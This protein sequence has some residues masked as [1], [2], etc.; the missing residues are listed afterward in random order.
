[1][2]LSPRRT[3]WTY[4]LEGRSGPM[5]WKDGVDLSLGRTEWTF[6]LEG[7]IGNIPVAES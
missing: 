6:F 3:E 1:M 2:D 5:S 4:L 7:R